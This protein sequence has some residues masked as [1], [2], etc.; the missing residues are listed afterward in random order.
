[1]PRS[2][3]ARD[4]AAAWLPEE[5]VA[6]PRRAAAADSAS[7]ALVAPRALKAPIFCRF[8][9]LKNSRAPLCA[10]SVALV[11]TGVA[12]TRL[13]MR[14]RAVAII[15]Q[16]RLS[17]AAGLAAMVHEHGEAGGPRSR[18]ARA[19][20]ARGGVSAGRGRPGGTGAAARPGEPARY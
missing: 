1:M 9:H 19:H 15:G 2:R 12:L 10:S 4:S 5:C 6:T 3:A 11:S 8:S 7:T 18:E 13:A 16:V 17:T 14:S 20:R